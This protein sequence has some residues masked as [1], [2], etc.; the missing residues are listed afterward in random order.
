MDKREEAKEILGRHPEVR[1]TVASGRR[2]TFRAGRGA[3]Q[4]TEP[5]GKFKVSG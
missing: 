2:E 4:R 1:R 5:E 3:R